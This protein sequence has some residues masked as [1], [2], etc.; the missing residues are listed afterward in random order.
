MLYVVVPNICCMLSWGSNT[1]TSGQECLFLQ[2]HSK[3]VDLVCLI[4]M[5]DSMGG[6]LLLYMRDDI[7]T[8]LL[9]HDFPPNICQVKWV[10]NKES[11]FSVAHSKESG[12]SVALWVTSMLQ[13]VIR[14]W[15]SFVFWTI[16]KVWLKIQHVIK[17]MTIQHILI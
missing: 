10:H 5:I 9:K 15:N 11:F 16:L 3:Y 4:D 14:V 8:K 6:W 13:W 1:T 7:P 17:I 12:F 2:V